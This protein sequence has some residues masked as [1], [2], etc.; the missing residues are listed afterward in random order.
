[1]CHHALD[2]HHKL[3]VFLGTQHWNQIIGL[4]NEADVMQAHVGQRSVEVALACPVRRARRQ[5]AAG[6]PAIPGHLGK[7]M[8]SFVE[9]AAEAV[10]EVVEEKQA[11]AA[12]VEAKAEEAAA[13]AAA[14]APASDDVEESPEEPAAEAAAEDDGE[15]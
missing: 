2:L 4:E 12:A 9:A 11:A 1:M 13:S 5:A 15:E 7:A 10:E 3:D 14:E 8:E 6:E